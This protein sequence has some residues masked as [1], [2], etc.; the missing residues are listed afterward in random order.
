M[1]SNTQRLLLNINGGLRDV[2]NKSLLSRNS[3]EGRKKRRWMKSVKEGMVGHNI[4]CRLPGKW[5]SSQWSVRS[6]L[7]DHQG[8]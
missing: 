1:F 3:L 4:N 2:E 6:E 5:D 7:R 8:R